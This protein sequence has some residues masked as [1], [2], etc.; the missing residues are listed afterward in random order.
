LQSLA[1]CHP[2]G[3]PMLHEQWKEQTFAACASNIH[4]RTEGVR[5]K[6]PLVGLCNGKRHGMNGPIV[7]P[8][9]E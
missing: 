6:L 9:G 1:I 8:I 2:G 4:H 5:T 7:T 3:G